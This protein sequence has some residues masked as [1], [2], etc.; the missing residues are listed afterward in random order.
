MGF[1]ITVYRTRYIQQRIVAK[2]INNRESLV[3]R[4]NHLSHSSQV[5]RY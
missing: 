5:R 3:P 1:H 2:S 4:F